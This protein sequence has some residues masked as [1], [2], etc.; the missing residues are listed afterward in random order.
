MRIYELNY[1]ISPELSEEDVKM[2]REKIT[3][4]IQE[5]EGVLIE[6]KPSFKKKL[7]YPVK[8]HSLAFLATVNFRLLPEK[9]KDLEK[10][11]KEEKQILRYLIL[12]RPIIKQTTLRKPKIRK[13]EKVKKGKVELKEIEKK[14]EE[15][16]AQS[17]EE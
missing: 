17:D 15:I 6:E 3:S 10:K 8:K 5:K 7:A 1:L 12:I 4:L 13:I 14:L 16:L 11:I 9:L 2:L